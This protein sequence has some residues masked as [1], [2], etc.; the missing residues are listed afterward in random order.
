M[1]PTLLMPSQMRQL[2]LRRSPLH[3]LNE[4]AAL[5]LPRPHTLFFAGR[6]CGDRTEP[7]S[8]AWPNCGDEQVSFSGQVG[9]ELNS[10]V[11]GFDTHL[12]LSVDDG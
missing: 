10:G 5:G 6:I 2:G 3:P 1:I 8:G 4:K 9:T 11:D 12:V 7:D